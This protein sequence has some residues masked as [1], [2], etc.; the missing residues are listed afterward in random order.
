MPKEYNNKG[1]LFELSFIYRVFYLFHVELLFRYDR[2][3]TV[4]I[5]G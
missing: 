5:L 2:I 3:P 4:N 1:E